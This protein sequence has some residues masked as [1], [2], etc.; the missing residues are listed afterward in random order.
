MLIQ[1]FVF[2]TQPLSNWLSEDVMDIISFSP[3]PLLR[4]PPSTT[5]PLVVRRGK[6]WPK[7]KPHITADQLKVR[8]EKGAILA[9][10]VEQKQKEKKKKQI[11][12]EEKK[13][14]IMKE[15]KMK[16]EKEQKE[17][18]KEEEKKN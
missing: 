9:T 14:K 8:V 7:G 17:K 18:R 10:M 1:V 5:T 11:L 15:L 6:G 4:P 13:K 16:L 12:K 2:L 3:P